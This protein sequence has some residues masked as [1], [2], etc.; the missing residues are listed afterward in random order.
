MT[1]YQIRLFLQAGADAVKVY[2]DAGRLTEFNSMKD[3][4]FPFSWVEELKPKTTFG[5]S[6]ASLIDDWSV[7]I[8]IAKLDKPDSIQDQYESI[9]DDCDDI[10]RK[11]IW[12]YNIVLQTSSNI[13]TANQDLYKL[14][15]LSDVSRDPFYKWGADP[16]TGVDLSFTLNSPD[17]T[18]VCP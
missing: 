12:Q 13:T 8:R 18:D 15:T 6:G 11:L 3:K 1:R 9:V 16:L 4:G 2:F 10:A 14:V 7:K 5:G 17:K